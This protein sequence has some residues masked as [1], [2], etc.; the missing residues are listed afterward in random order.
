MR[1]LVTLDGSPESE[2]VLPDAAA[3]ARAT[4]A[5]VHVLRVVLSPGAGDP[6]HQRSARK[7]D[8]EQHR[9]E[10]ETRIYLEQRKTPFAGLEVVSVVRFGEDEDAAAVIIAYA[11]T[12]HVD[13]IAMATHGRSGLSELLHGSVAEAVIRSGVAP[14]LVRRPQGGWKGW[15]APA[16]S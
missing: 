13:L 8:E 15:E 1:M 14:V 6:Y 11:E 9:R 16:G 7:L 12:H 5:E 4:G 10:E 3:V 2:S